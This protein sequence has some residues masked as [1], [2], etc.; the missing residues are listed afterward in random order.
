MTETICVDILS[1]NSCTYSGPY[2]Q[3]QE[4]ARAALTESGGKIVNESSSEGF[5][6]GRFRVGINAF[7]LRVRWEFRESHNGN[8]AIETHGRFVDAFDTF[9]KAQQK[10]S[11]QIEQF[12]E[13]MIATHSAVVTRH[14]APSVRPP[15]IN[16]YVQVPQKHISGKS[17]KAMAVW[18]LMLGIFSILLGGA[19]T[20]FLA[21]ILGALGR[22]KMGISNNYAGKKMAMA[23]IVFGVI[24]TLTGSVL[25]WVVRISQS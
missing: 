6:E 3:A 15:S 5:I 1:P 8:I 2:L 22:H 7:G 11:E 13:I 23:G 17:N 14:D 20:G 18:S 12:C 19:A 24:A 10:A 4:A 9:G 21:V 16:S 25:G